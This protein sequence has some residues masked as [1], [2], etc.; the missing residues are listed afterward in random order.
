MAEF[1]FKQCLDAM[2]IL[3]YSTSYLEE[4][5]TINWTWLLWYYLSA[6]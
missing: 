1:N 6:T 5:N 4:K 2:M 3:R